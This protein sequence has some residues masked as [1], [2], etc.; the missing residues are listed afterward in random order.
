VE[1]IKKTKRSEIG[2]GGILFHFFFFF[3]VWLSLNFEIMKCDPDRSMILDSMKST[4]YSCCCDRL[5]ACYLI[6]R[7]SSGSV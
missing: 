6:T 7:C 1:Y 2:P 4:A 3:L 5:I